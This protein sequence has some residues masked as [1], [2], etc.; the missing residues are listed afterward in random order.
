MIRQRLS[1]IKNN[2]FYIESDETNIGVTGIGAP[3]FN[4]RKEITAAVGVIGPSVQL[5][6]NELQQAKTALM[7]ATQEIS[8]K[9]GFAVTITVQPSDH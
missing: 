9:M 7:D 2:G 6:G 8:A 4:A 5:A 3:V 1:Q